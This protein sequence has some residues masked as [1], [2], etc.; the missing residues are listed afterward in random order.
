MSAAEHDAI[1]QSAI[2]ILFPFIF[3]EGSFWSYR[4]SVVRDGWIGWIGGMKAYD[5]GTHVA[6]R[7]SAGIPPKAGW[8]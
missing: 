5:A 1:R 6:T 7:V 4:L 3:D 2:V 8:I